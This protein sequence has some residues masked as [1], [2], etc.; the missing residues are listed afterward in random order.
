MN[1]F[2]KGI[3]K[4]FFV[5]LAVVSIS[6]CSCNESSGNDQYLYLK[7]GVP[8]EL[9]VEIVNAQEDTIR[10][11]DFFGPDLIE[12]AKAPMKKNEKN[13]TATLKGFVPVEGIYYLG[14]GPQKGK[15]IVLGEAGKIRVQGED[16][17]L[18]QTFKAQSKL[19]ELY[20]ALMSE[21]MDF[22]NK[23][24]QAGAKF[25]QN[26]SD[27]QA[28][29]SF[30]SLLVGQYKNFEKYFN[31][32]NVI[33]KLAKLMAYKPYKSDPSH[34]K[35]KDEVEYFLKEFI[36]PEALSDTNFAYLP[37]YFDKMAYYGQ[38]VTSLF[39]PDSVLL[40]LHQFTNT[41]ILSKH[42][43]VTYFAWIQA[44]QQ[45]NQDLFL[46]I[47]E[48]Y[49]KDFPA[50]HKSELIKTIITQNSALKKGS[51]AP[52]LAFPNPEGKV[53]KL[54]DLRGKVVLIDFWASWCGPCRRENPNVVAMY[55][56][57]KDKGFEIYS[58][59]LDN[60]KQKWIEAIQKDGLIWKSHS[61]ELKGWQSS[62]CQTY[63][64]NSIPH[65]VLL[66]RQGRIVAKGLRG[67]AL[68]DK[69]VEL[70]NQK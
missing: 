37:Q 2:M 52:E 42:K 24:Q 1:Y 34:A 61:S 35:Y 23:I 63:Q 14:Y 50:G 56:R 59:S 33:G 7:K 28:K 5:G 20:D 9:E 3:L 68:E 57:L 54:S 46:E 47:C 17:F 49:I 15:M 41:K 4:Y 18:Q 48:K 64:F 45:R 53:V 29:K 19:N 38:T 44:T 58:F 43:G 60:D 65:T 26:Q 31:Q 8:F 13:S 30:D 27:I 36:S 66:D 12:L 16:P 10:V 11:F 67:K 32:N 21:T 62:V 69:V 6:L 39:P 70:L 25:S 51:V 40:K 22:Q 55:N